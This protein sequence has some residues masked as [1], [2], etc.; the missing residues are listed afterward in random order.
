M[1]A[2]TAL[3]LPI[4][5]SAVLVFILAALAWMVAPHHKGEWKRLASEDAVRAAMRA[6]P[7]AP[8]LYM[9]PFAGSQQARGEPGFA[10][11]LE[12][13]PVAHITVAK[14]GNMS[15]GPM[16]AQSVAYYLV[17]GAIVAYVAGHVLPAG[18]PYLQVFR[19]VGTAAWLA[20]GFGTVPESIWFAKPW[21]STLK[22]AFDALIFAMAT[23]GVF[24]WLWPK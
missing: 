10:K 18:T 20:Y 16:M 9:I 15:M 12:E 14:S 7:P 24:G 23:A 19:V 22:Q 4:A 17:V 6:S 1:V 21:S 13:G 2:M 5:L 8:G 11:K 3:I